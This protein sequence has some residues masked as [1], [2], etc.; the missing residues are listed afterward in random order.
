[1]GTTSNGCS[2]LLLI[3]LLGASPALCRAGELCRRLGEMN[4][5]ND[6][7][8]T[9]MG[10]GFKTD[11]EYFCGPEAPQQF[12]CG[13]GTAGICVERRDPWG[14]DVGEC[15]CCPVWVWC[16]LGVFCLLLL[17]TAF[18]VL[19]AC[20]LRGKWWFDG[21]PEAIQP[22]LPRRGPPAVVPAG[23]PLPQTLFRGYRISDFIS[24]QPPEPANETASAASA[25]PSGS[26]TALRNGGSRS[27]Q[28]VR[29]TPTNL[30]SSAVR[31]RAFIYPPGDVAPEDQGT[32]QGFRDAIRATARD[33]DDDGRP[34]SGDSSEARPR[35]PQLHN[36]RAAPSAAHQPVTSSASSR[37]NSDSSNRSH[38]AVSGSPPTGGDPLEEG[39]PAAPR[40][41]PLRTARTAVAPVAHDPQR[42]AADHT[43]SNGRED[44]HSS[45]SNGRCPE[46]IDLSLL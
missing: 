24:E 15:G 5:V 37:V 26:P 17:A 43:S 30:S 1:M 31:N 8:M 39:G 29:Q 45:T 20:C 34:S 6:E 41:G 14:R 44:N 10:Y 28:V 16:V 3:A 7:F 46:S 35:V 38:G 21:Y 19:Y 4:G 42:G 12:A 27:A 33:S 11:S 32:L 40:L 36:R 22:L 18:M 13:C 9:A 23:M 2:V 25:A